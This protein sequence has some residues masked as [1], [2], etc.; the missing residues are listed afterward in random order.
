MPA[1][2]KKTTTVK[3]NIL[4]VSQEIFPYLADPTP[5]RELNRHLPEFCR[6]KGWETRTFMPKFG[7]INERR[8]QVH[9]VI[10]L[11]GLNLIVN[12]TDR[13]L[14]VKVASIMSAKI[15]IYF[16]DNEDFFHKRKGI[17]DPTTGVD[18]ADNDER[19]IFFSRGVIETLRKVCWGPDIIYCSGWMSALVP[20]YVRTAFKNDPFFNHAKIVFALDNQ[21]FKKPFSTKFANKLMLPSILQSDV[22]SLAG[23]P[24]QWEDLMRFGIEY[25]D[26]VML[27]EEKVNQRL[28][29]YAENNKKQLVPFNGL[30]K[31]KYFEIFEN[32][33]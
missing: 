30:D 3:K 22:R 25:S 33:V 1:S 32:L 28:I 18:Y 19:C 9:E 10:R 14:V 29:N 23:L 16:I 6:A 20:F 4:F 5:I 21:S 13:P 7:D 26:V 27:N 8:N 2:P 31:E 24:V 12:E 11:S 17:V 15:Q